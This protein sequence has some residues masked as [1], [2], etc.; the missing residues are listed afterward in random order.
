IYA[1]AQKNIGPAGLTVVIMR[2]DLMGKAAAG[3]PSMLDYQVHADADSMSNTPPTFAW[4]LS[5]L[6]F[7]WLKAQ[8]GLS[9]IAEVNRRKAAKLYEAIDNSNFY[10]S[11][12]VV[13]N[14]SQMNV[15][16][17]LPDSEL[18]AVF[19]KRADAAGLTNLK[20]HRS[21]GGMRASIYNAVPEA[22]VDALIEFM[23]E[24][25]NEQS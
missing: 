13:E 14:R 9:A 19:L 24:F 4:Y 3:V 12:V 15:P 5:G 16:F 17:T 8:G 25:E 20:G 22:A 23:G 18:D 2:R 6:V 21:V 1:G 11:P 10:S 7:E